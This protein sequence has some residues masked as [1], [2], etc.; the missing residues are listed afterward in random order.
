MER[1]CHRTRIRLMT[2]PNRRRRAGSG[3]AGVL[4][5]GLALSACTATN[6][7]NSA[8]PGAD[9]VGRVGPAATMTVD[10]AAHQATLLADGTVLVTGGFRAGE[11]GLDSAE[12]YDPATGTFRPTGPMVTTRKAGHT[13]VR[14]G[15]GQVLVAGGWVGRDITASAELYDPVTER[16]VPTGSMSSARANSAA[17]LL[18][19][20]SVLIAGGF[21]GRAALATVEIYDPATG[22]FRETGRLGV[23]RRAAVG[24]PLGDGRILV[25]GG[26]LA[27]AEVYDPAVGTFAATGSMGSVR[28]KAAAVALPGG[29]V[30][31]LGG[32]DSRDWDGQYDT[33]EVYDSRTGAFTPVGRMHAARF[34][35]GSAAVALPSGAVVVAGSDRSVETYDPTR[36]TFQQGSGQLDDE[37]QSGTATALTDGRVLIAGGYDRHIRPTAQT[38]LFVPPA[39]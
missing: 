16:F 17:A 25:T 6:P 7:T 31:V 34:K 9:R 14:L 13:A 11:V 28:D 36:Q 27:S 4:S 18:P 23:A 8:Q 37:Y 35:I 20:G 15:T 10:R 1:V 2:R 32:S 26:L 29:R 12:L 22:T 19:D 5:A 3:V 38:W 33:A 30:L 24:A 21:D 39:I